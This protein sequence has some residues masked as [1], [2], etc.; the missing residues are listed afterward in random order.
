MSRPPPITF[1][2]GLFVQTQGQLDLDSPGQ[3]VLKVDEDQTPNQSIRQIRTRVRL[4]LLSDER[5]AWARAKWAEA[6]SA[7]PWRHP[8][9]LSCRGDSS[10]TATADR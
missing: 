9:Q 4:G 1:A 2:K 6:V 7:F 5:P 10:M 3:V 8:V